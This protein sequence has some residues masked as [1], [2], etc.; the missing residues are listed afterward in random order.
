[1]EIAVKAQVG[2]V[3]TMRTPPG[4]KELEIIAIHYD[5]LP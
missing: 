3:V 5:K 2:D 4:T 1:L